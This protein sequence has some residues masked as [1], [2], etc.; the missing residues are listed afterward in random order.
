MNKRWLQDVY[1]LGSPDDDEGQT[2]VGTIQR[3]ANRRDWFAY[4]CLDDW[5]DTQLGA[6]DSEL[7]ARRAV[8]HWVEENLR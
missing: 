4:G 2:V 6:F 7:E 5:E 8:E 3:G 1:V